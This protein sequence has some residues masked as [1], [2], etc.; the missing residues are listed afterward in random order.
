MNKLIK[1]YAHDYR[2][3]KLSEAEMEA[4]LTSFFMDTEMKVYNSKLTFVW[5]VTVMFLLVVFRYLLR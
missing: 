1:D 2:D 5:G 3:I 4:M